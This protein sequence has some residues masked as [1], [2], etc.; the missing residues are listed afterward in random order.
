MTALV[1]GELIKAT[2]TRT[3]L[4]YASSA[5]FLAVLA[6]VIMT[7]TQD[8]TSIGDKETALAGGPIL[9]LLLGIVGA[10]GEYRHRTAAPAALVAPGRGRLLTARAAAY[11][12]TG[13]AIGAAMVAVTLAVGLPLLESEP[14]TALTAG[15][16]ATVAGGSVAAAVLSAIMGVAVGTLLRN[17]VAGVVGALVLAFIVE[18]LVGTLSSGAVDYLPIGSA[19]ALAGQDTS[20]TLSATG[21]LLV[22]LAWTVPLVVAAIVSERRRDVA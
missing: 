15:D 8:L 16:V 21:A 10:A 19:S 2:T 20:G 12:L 17:Q 13:L 1:R 7:Q 11:G 9:L 6:L 5:L 22:L 3:L 4:A 14:G 18:P